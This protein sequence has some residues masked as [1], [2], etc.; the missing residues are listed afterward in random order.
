M[1]NKKSRIRQDD[2]NF[3]IKTIYVT[4]KKLR[5]KRKYINYH[6]VPFFEERKEIIL[7]CWTLPTENTKMYLVQL[8]WNYTQRCVK[9]REP[10]CVVKDGGAQGGTGWSI[11][12]RWPRS[13]RSRD[14][15]THRS[16]N[17]EWSKEIN[18]PLSFP[19]F[20]LHTPSPLF[21]KALQEEPAQKL[22]ETTKHRLFWGT[23]T[24]AE[25]NDVHIKSLLT[26]HSRNMQAG[27][28]R[29]HQRCLRSHAISCSR[30]KTNL[31]GNGSDGFCGNCQ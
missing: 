3:D 2:W 7:F 24:K 14:R 8:T 31:A 18:P 5:G 26:E 21:K 16:R 10:G 19:S 4:F 9:V 30:E 13:G 20:P 28:C 15:P 11:T 29:G 12:E 22:S 27:V 6:P 25:T 1:E 17:L 23:R